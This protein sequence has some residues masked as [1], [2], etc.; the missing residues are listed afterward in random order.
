[1]AIDY[2][3]WCPT[4]SPD[5][6]MESLLQYHKNYYFLFD[7]QAV[8]NLQ[9]LGILNVFYL[10][11]AIDFPEQIEVYQDIMQSDNTKESPSSYADGYMKGLLQIKKC[12]GQYEEN[13]PADKWLDFQNSYLRMHSLE[14]RLQ[15]VI[16]R[17][18]SL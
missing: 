8:R 13:L 18:S 9:Q 15:S 11:Y 16:K 12:I 17:V 10:P 4:L 5:D 6:I 2:I 1:M 3:C 14:K 7:R